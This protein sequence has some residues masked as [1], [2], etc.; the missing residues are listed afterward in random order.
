MGTGS[1]GGCQN[2]VEGNGPVAVDHLHQVIDDTIA[3]SR[4]GFIREH[5]LS[6]SYPFGLSLLDLRHHIAHESPF[7]LPNVITHGRDQR[8]QSQLGIS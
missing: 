6:F 1:H 3:V 4:H 5:W 2:V 8:L 7:P